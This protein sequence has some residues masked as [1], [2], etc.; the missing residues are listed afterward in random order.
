VIRRHSLEVARAIAE[1]GAANDLLQRL[2][3]DPAFR[4]VDVAGVARDLDPLHYCGRA[5]EQV[6]EFLRDVAQPLLG[7]LGDAPACELRV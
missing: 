7:Q 3:A 2:A 5:P 1:E 4:G 6:D